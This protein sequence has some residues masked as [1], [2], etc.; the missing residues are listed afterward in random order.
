M[1]RITILAAAIIAIAVLPGA[2]SAEVTFGAIYPTGGSHGRGGLDEAEGVRLAVE[3]VNARGGLNGKRVRLREVPADAAEQTPGAV[4]RLA[5]AGIPLIFGSYGSTLSKPAAE[6]SEQRG[7]VFFETGAVGHLGMAASKG[8]LVFRFP[9]T[10]ETLG[11]EAV[12]FGV[13]QVIPGLKRDPADLR[14]AVAYV[15]DVYGRS[16]GEG[17]VAEAKARGLNLAGV[18]PYTMPGVDARAIIAAVKASRADVLFIS[19][20]LEDGIALRK[21]SV[22]QKLPLL[23]SVGTSSSYCMHEFGAALGDDAIGLFASDKP[24]GHVL[25]PA[26]LRPDAAAALVWARTR[27]AERRDHEMTAPGL[28][29]FAGAYAVL[30]HVLP[31][32][33]QLTP[34]AIAEALRSADVP[35]GALPNASGLDFAPGSTDNLRATSVIWQWVAR[36]ERAVVWPPTFA[37]RELKVIPI[38]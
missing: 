24:D 5:D 25:D 30:H 20:Y 17:A 6:R 15:D 19:A 22:R 23:A 36:G 21:E 10:G 8:D 26:K 13:E 27:F 12:S 33:K 2:A 14:Y 11:R 18:F 28:T 32:V 7:V 34:S 29:G 1:R 37:T 38:R 4:D 31:G 16:V 3:Y 9:P 35:L